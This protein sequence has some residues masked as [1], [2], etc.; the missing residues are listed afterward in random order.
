MLSTRWVL[1]FLF[2]GALALAQRAGAQQVP[3][4]LYVPHTGPAAF[5]ASK[6]P[7]ILIDGGHHNFHTVDGRYSAFARLA[8]RDGYQVRGSTGELSDG[9][10]ASVDILVIANPLAA[11]NDNGR[12]TLLTP[13]AFTVEEIAS[14]RRWVEHGGSLLLIAD[15]MPFGGA[16]EALGTAMGVSWINGFA[17]DGRQSSI[18]RLSR[19][20]GLAAHSIFDGRSAAERV[21]SIVAFTGSAFWLPHGGAPLIFIPP[22]S[23]VLLPRVAWQFSD[24]TASIGATGMLQGAALIVGQGRM[25]AAG[26]AAMFSAQRAGREGATM[27]GFN[28][29][30]APQNAQFVLNVLHWLSKLLPES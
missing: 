29:P 18:F 28:D 12:W 8:R 24:S 3:D 21:D 16:V 13:S 10:L 20:A 6:G 27:M 17:Y 14:V 4:T 30:S 5:T 11:Q 15:H 22:D 2:A 26:E 9:S 23:R 25:V 19:R 1:N 7:R